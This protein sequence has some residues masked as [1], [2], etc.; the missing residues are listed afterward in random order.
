MANTTS[1]R[2]PIHHHALAILS[3][4]LA[5]WH[6]G[7]YHGKPHH[8]VIDSGLNVMMLGVA[9]WLGVGVF[10]LRPS[11]DITLSAVVSSA[12]MNETTKIE[13]VVRNDSKVK[14]QGV[15][16]SSR[17]PRDWK[18]ISPSADL[19]LGQIDAGQSAATSLQIALA[20]RSG[21]SYPLQIIV[22][23]ERDGQPV[24]Q[25]ARL[26][27]QPKPM[28]VSFSPM[29][30]VATIGRA[31]T[32]K[33]T[34]QSSAE[35]VLPTV[36][37]RLRETADVSVSPNHETIQSEIPLGEKGEFTFTV[38]PK[39]TGFLKLPMEIGMMTERGFVIER[40]E[41]VTLQSSSSSNP[42][43]VLQSVPQL[44]ANMSSEAVYYSAVGFQFGYGA[45]PPRVDQETTF[46]IFWHIRPSSK[47]GTNAV[48]TARLPSGV[49]WAG[50]VSVTAGSAI[51]VSNSTV[52]WA[53]GS[54]N[55][56][57][58]VMTG[59]FDVRLKP[60]SGMVG[61][62]PVLVHAASLTYR[63]PDGRQQVT[64]SG[65]TTTRTADP[66]NPTFGRVQ[67]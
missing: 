34:Y 51:T 31:A 1:S 53:I 67:R 7:R 46:R 63:D 57:Q 40:V 30:T 18:N 37:V 9:L 50:N 35:S 49:Q 17:L 45:F 11:A 8:L 22:R 21:R 28:R 59:S 4:I 14:V 61:Q 19:V 2:R 3:P 58:E 32:F 12:Y 15:Q 13:V 54:W 27:L 26:R 5:H 60:G 33:L 24:L 39:R 20:G 36:A 6:H 38:T 41:S 55:A 44:G 65:S 16:V 23:G 29:Q 48:V 56:G 25:W 10:F 52:R 42:E 66:K 62:Y 43:D 64:K 47:T